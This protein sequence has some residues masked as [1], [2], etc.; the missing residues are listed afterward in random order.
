MAAPEAQEPSSFIAVPG[1]SGLGYR[2]RRLLAEI[3]ARNH[4]DADY[5]AA[6]ISHESGWRPT[7]RNPAS[8]ATGI[9]QWTDLSARA[10]DTT[11][12]QIAR[13]SVY[14]Q[15]PLV[16]RYFRMASSGRPIQGP[17]FMVYALGA[18]HCPTLTD[19][20]VMYAAGSQGAVANPAFCDEDG[21]IRVGGVRRYFQA[22]VANYAERRR[23]PVNVEQ[24]WAVT[25]G[26][27]LKFPAPLL[28]VAGLAVVAFAGPRLIRYLGRRN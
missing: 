23:Q 5:V 21:A 12:R 14:E 15:L 1:L 18:G 24:E 20:C 26:P 28:A 22:W 25:G 17:D 2:E 19:D 27:R 13:M 16:E 9:L 4:W 11:T 10:L 6:V 7:A 3:A 8:S